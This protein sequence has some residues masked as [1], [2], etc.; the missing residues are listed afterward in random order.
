MGVSVMGR[1]VPD[2]DLPVDGRV[3][4]RVVPEHDLPEN[5]DTGFM[6]EIAHGVGN[7]A[8]GAIRGAGSIGATFLAPYDIAKDALNG[9]GLSLES[10]RQRRA[11]IDGGLQ[12]MGA[13]PNSFMYKAGKL[14]GEIAGTAGAGG[15]LANGARAVPVLARL[16][17]AIESGGFRTGANL[18][19]ATRGAKTADMATRIIGGA[20]N[21]GVT[22]AMVDPEHAGT[23]AVIGSALPPSVAALGS[24]GRSIGRIIRGPS[25]SE[26]VRQAVETARNAGYVI[27]PSQAKPTLVNRLLEGFS[28]KITTAQNASARNQQV[29]Q[30]VIGKELGLPA[31]TPV[32]L[33]ALKAVR[34]EAGKAYEAVSSAGTIN[35]TP[36]YSAALD[37][38]MASAK[39]ASAGFPNAKPN[40]LIAEIESL[41]TPQM[42]AS[43][44]VAKIKE[45]RNDA[46][47]AYRAGN[48]ELGKALKDGAG[49]IEDA[50]DTHLQSIGAPQQVLD[51][52]RNARQLI[53]K[54]YSVE[55]AMNATTGNVD[56]VKLGQQL[57]KG[58]PLSGGIRTAAEFG[59]QFPK[60][61]Q[62]IERMG[63]LP[64]T[65]PLDWAA[66]GAMTA[67]L[68]NPLFMASVLARP[69]ARKAV[70]SDLVQNRLSNPQQ[71]NAIMQLLTNPQSQSLLYRSAPVAIDR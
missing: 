39:K 5:H 19:N 49:A 3:T 62:T 40:P 30:A 71:N 67:G 6:S 31:G 42:D 13:D 58:K 35:T 51:G 4:W 66:G 53:A 21:G 1:V 70:L 45:L 23:G 54:T 68:H 26:P 18:V 69:A 33:D 28:G 2:H 50:I 9:K 59:Q 36:E 61:A 48:K 55:K 47:S 46:D 52:F 44:A 41:K 24:A 43:S 56:A 12:E 65:S 64:Q 37:K 32:S 17:P 20:I 10:N 14:G 25:V 22:T 34:N 16:A 63:S 8:A 7:L 27:P 15:V 57:A 38:I 29:T 60:A 11:A